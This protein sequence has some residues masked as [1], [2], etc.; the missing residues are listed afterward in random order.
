[1]SYTHI[2]KIVVDIWGLLNQ[3]MMLLRRLN[4]LVYAFI[5]KLCGIIT[6]DEGVATCVLEHFVRHL[7]TENLGLSVDFLACFK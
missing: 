2:H 5:V 3:N 6:K 1:M 4:L 7:A